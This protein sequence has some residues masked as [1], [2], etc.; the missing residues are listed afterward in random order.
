MLTWPRLAVAGA[1]AAGTAIALIVAIGIPSGGPAG[2]GAAPRVGG[3]P[4]HLITLDALLQRAAAVA[5]AQ[6]EPRG[7]QFVYSDS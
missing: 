6:P 5:A 3:P 2:S 4:G 7:D 1:V